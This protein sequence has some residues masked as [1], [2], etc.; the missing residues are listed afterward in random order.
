L[1]IGLKIILNSSDG[2]EMKYFYVLGKIK[3]SKNGTS[4]GHAF[5]IPAHLRS[6]PMFAAC[7]L[8]NAEIQFNFGETAFKHN[9]DEGYIRLANAPSNC[10]AATTK[11]GGAA[12]KVSCFALPQDFLKTLYKLTL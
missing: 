2:F 6:Q 10:S 12:T 4:L 11:T 5:D 1:L 7:V 9:P 8:K 3:F